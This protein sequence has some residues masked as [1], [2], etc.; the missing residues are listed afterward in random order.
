MMD[1]ARLQ[2]RNE[3]NKPVQRGKAR[4]DRRQVRKTDAR[5]L[6]TTPK[7]RPSIVDGARPRSLD[8]NDYLHSHGKNWPGFAPRA[9]ATAPSN[10]ASRSGLDRARG[11][12]RLTVCAARLGE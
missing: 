6:E 11:C 3:D 1:R 9:T 7:R 2:L 12:R 10:F 5:L 8:A 4:G